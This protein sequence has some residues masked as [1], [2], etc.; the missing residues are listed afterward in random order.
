MCWN[1]KMSISEDAHG[2]FEG[3]VDIVW[4]AGP[5]RT[6]ISRSFLSFF[7]HF[8]DKKALPVHRLHTECF[9]DLT[10]LSVSLC[11]CSC[12]LLFGNVKRLSLKACQCAD[13]DSVFSAILGLFW[14]VWVELLLL[15][16]TVK[17]M[18][19]QRRISLQ[20]LVWLL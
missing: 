6:L 4:P 11:P 3:R 2:L 19:M 16:Y 13:P 7:F 9:S 10:D 20:R 5:N 8:A 12:C 1:A 18:Q 15:F 17:T 14:Q